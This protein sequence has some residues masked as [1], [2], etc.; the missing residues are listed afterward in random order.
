VWIIHT[1]FILFDGLHVNLH[2]NGLPAAALG[3]K[4]SI[5]PYFWKFVKQKCKILQKKLFPKNWH[6]LTC[7]PSV[8]PMSST[9]QT[10]LKAGDRIPIVYGRDLSVKSAASHMAKFWIESAASGTR[11]MD[12]KIGKTK[13]FWY[14]V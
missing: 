5:I 13:N 3:P 2:V 11:H 7:Q 12:P 1:F 6:N 9:R 14:N 10:R 4:I 8:N